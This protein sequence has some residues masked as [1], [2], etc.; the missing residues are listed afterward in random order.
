MRVKQEVVFD[1]VFL[2]H[3]IGLTAQNDLFHG[4]RMANSS[5]CLTS[6]SSSLSRFSI[7]ACFGYRDEDRKHHLNCTVAT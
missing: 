4:A 3:Q 6:R 2:E 7:G 5:P 1:L